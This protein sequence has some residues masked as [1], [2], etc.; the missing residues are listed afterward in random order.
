MHLL[1]VDWVG[2]NP[3]N[4]RKVLLSVAFIAGVLLCSAIKRIGRLAT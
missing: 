1:G 3:Q 4:G 2:V